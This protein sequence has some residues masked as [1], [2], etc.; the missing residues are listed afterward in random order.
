MRSCRWGER[1]RTVTSRLERWCN[2]PC[3]F[4][5]LHVLQPLLLGD[6]AQGGRVGT[7]FGT[8][9][10]PMVFVMGG[11]VLASQW[12]DI[13]SGDGSTVCRGL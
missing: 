4:P 12:D 6:A 5:Y 2:V 11:G 3:A 9:R 13:K 7:L 1:S 8:C 10:G